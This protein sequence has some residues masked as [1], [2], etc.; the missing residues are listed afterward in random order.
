M[1]FEEPVE[2]IPGLEAEQPPQLGLGDVTALEFFERQ[3][4]EGTPREI[5]ANEAVQTA[6]LGQAA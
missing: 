3:S 5:A 4:F 1:G 6:Y 2:L